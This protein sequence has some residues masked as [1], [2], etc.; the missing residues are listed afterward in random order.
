MFQ[1]YRVLHD[2]SNPQSTTVDHTTMDGPSD[3]PS[4]DVPADAPDTIV[5]SCATHR[6]V[7][8]QTYNRR[9]KK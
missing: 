9:G 5:R 2:P 3:A 8:R 4:M 6:Q 7:G 1:I